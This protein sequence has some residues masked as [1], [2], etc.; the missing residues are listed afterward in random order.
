MDTTKLGKLGV[1]AASI[2]LLAACGD[3][4]KVA[5]TDDTS[6][7]QLVQT[8]DSL[9]QVIANQDSLLSL[10]NE[11]GDGME[12][13]KMLENILSSEN[14]QSETPDRRD[15]IRNDMADIQRTLNERRQRLAELEARLNKSNANNAHLRQAITSLKSQIAAQ[16]T[17]IESLRKDLASANIYID[18]L[19]QNVDSLNTTVANTIEEKNVVEQKNEELTNQLNT[20]YYVIG[21]KSELKA[22]DIIETGFLKKTK[23]MPEDFQRNYFTTADQR[24]LTSL[25]LHSKKAKVLTSQPSDSYQIV[26]DA[27]GMKVLNITNPEKFWSTYKYLVIQ[28]D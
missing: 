22:H 28:V 4:K 19:T 27:N 3:E 6:V 20:C 12:Q 11:L 2:V 5:S 23:I 18:Q 25:P 16:V 7:D 24:S 8:R 10:I 17:T 21:S 26:N 1:F 13:I 15:K 14:L 9:Q